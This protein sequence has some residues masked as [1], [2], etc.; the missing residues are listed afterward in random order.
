MKT[1]AIR[2]PH[3]WK[4]RIRSVL[5][6]SII[7]SSLLLLDA[8]AAEVPSIFTVDSIMQEGIEDRNFA[9]AIYESISEQIEKNNYIL[10]N[11]WNTKEILINYGKETPKNQRA[12]INAQKKGIKSINGIK[13][14]KN[15]HAIRL[16]S[17]N[18]H[19]LSPLKRDI[20]NEEDKLYF[21]K[22]QITIDMNNF[23]NVVPSELIGLY[24]GNI[25]VD[26][27]LQFDEEQVGYIYKDN[28]KKTIVLDFDLELDGQKGGCFNRDRSFSSS[29]NEINATYTPYAD[30]TNRYTG[31]EITIPQNDGQLI[32]AANANEDLGASYKP[33]I[34]F[35]TSELVDQKLNIEWRYP[36]RTKF[37]RTL[38]ND[39]TPVIYSG[40][41]LIKQDPDGN[42]LSGARYILWKTEGGSR[43]RYPDNSTEYITDSDGKLVIS[44]LPAGT[45]EIQETESPKGYKLDTVPLSF[46]VGENASGYFAS[47][48]S[49]GD[50]EASITSDDAEYAPVWDSIEELDEHGQLIRKHKM[51][52]TKGSTVSVTPSSLGV[53]ALISNYGTGLTHLKGEILD[54]SFI[55]LVPEASMIHVYAGDSLLG[56]FNDPSEAR[57]IINSMIHTGGFDS[58]KGNISVDAKIVYREADSEYKELIHVNEKEPEPVPEPEPKPEPE[59]PVIPAEKVTEITVIKTWSEDDHPEE[60]FFQLFTKK[61]DGT[62]RMV[63]KSKKAD[64]STNYIVSWSYKEIRSGTVEKASSSNAADVTASPSNASPSNASGDSAALYDEDGFLLDGMVMDDLGEDLFVEETQIPEGWEPV[65][66]RPETDMDGKVV[67]TVKNRR[68]PEEPEK[69]KKEEP[70]DEP[71]EIPDEEPDEI[72][73]EEPEK[74]RPT[75]SSGSPGGGD[76]VTRVTES[77]RQTAEEPISEQEVLGANRVLTRKNQGLP[78]GT[79]ASGKIPPM[80]EETGDEE[81]HAGLLLAVVLL[82]AALTGTG[83]RFIRRKREVNGNGK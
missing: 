81:K 63:G 64:R 4:K 24:G 20:E 19:D 62:V 26:S 23:Q 77:P 46:T 16:S 30:Y 2:N 10:D 42:S 61:E 52:L 13:L 47:T 83:S 73:D 72:P 28:E 82:L 41:K 33:T 21:N 27:T 37:Y 45:Y 43:A 29:I 14:L 39:F 75:G 57:E 70:G 40:V 11:N 34:H 32:I 51:R 78:Y 53:D 18:I 1:K 59:P 7:L 38:I 22:T 5:C 15:S 65:Y 58:S 31:T 12:I 35:W 49:G 54:D 55:S 6:I 74:N 76:P 17:N 67:F 69:Y 9:E 36:F 56:V 3:R 80:G 60:A 79:I 68:I 25:T 8:Y 71:D 50:T 48:V 44:D 66:S